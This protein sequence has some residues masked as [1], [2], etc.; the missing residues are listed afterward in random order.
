MTCLPLCRLELL[1]EHLQEIRMLRHQLEESI[2]TNNRLRKQLEQQVA[3]SALDQGKAFQD[4]GMKSEGD[5]APQ[6]ISS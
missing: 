4:Y 3:D 5:K 6:R 1:M 2:K